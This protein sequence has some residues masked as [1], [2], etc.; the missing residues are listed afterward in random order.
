MGTL[1]PTSHIYTYRSKTRQ[2]NQKFALKNKT[3][4]PASHHGQADT[5]NIN[6]N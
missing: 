6:N 5:D 1:L 3:E 2:A 4:H